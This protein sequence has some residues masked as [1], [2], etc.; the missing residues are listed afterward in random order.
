M[1]EP[2][3]EAI[4]DLVSDLGL[5]LVRVLRRGFGLAL[6][7]GARVH[8]LNDQGVAWGT[9]KRVLAPVSDAY[10]TAGGSRESAV[11]VALAG[12]SV[13]DLLKA[14]GARASVYD[15]AT[16]L[17]GFYLADPA[18]LSALVLIEQLQSEG[19]PGRTRIYRV[20]GGAD[21]IAERLRASA[22]LTVRVR[23]VIRAVTQDAGGVRV[24][25]EDSRSRLAT[26][27]ADYV[28]LTLPA[29]PLLAC[30]FSPM[31]PQEQRRALK[32]LT[33]GPATKVVLRSDRRWWRHSRRPNAYGSNLPTG[34]IWEAAEEQRDASMLML[35]AGGAASGQLQSILQ[36]D[37]VSAL[38]PHL[39][40]LGRPPAAPD[41]AGVTVWE[42]DPWARGGYAVLGPSLDS[43]ARRWLS[44]T[45][46]RVLFA[47]EHS[48]DHWQGYMNGAVETGM[49]AA[50]ELEALER[51]ARSTA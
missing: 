3:Q 28:I 27:S 20:E 29:T 47:G 7:R 37:G 12:Q 22:Q 8:L 35:L 44:R 50:A 6:R 39:R 25:I 4:R 1:I 11:G 17:R 34:A 49:R 21:Q 45:F 46:G 26:R 2:E 23:H 32:A 15:L 51:L 40:W 38:M 43:L 48:S 36:R 41:L 31:L 5:R 10:R 42:N 30:R 14:V 19:S 33:Y 16:A 13:A 9:L 18:E 24:A